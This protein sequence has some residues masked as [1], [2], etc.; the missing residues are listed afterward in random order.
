MEKVK[1]KVSDLKKMNPGRIFACWKTSDNEK[2]LNMMKR[3]DF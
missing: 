2:G 1:I 3:R